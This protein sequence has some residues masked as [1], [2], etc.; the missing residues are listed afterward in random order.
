MPFQGQANQQYQAVDEN[1]RDDS[2]CASQGHGLKQELPGYVLALCADGFADADLASALGHADEHDV[3]YAHP[4]D[5]QTHGTEH[6][7]GQ[8]YHSDDAVE[9]LYF[10]LGGANHEIILGVVSHVSAAAK[11]FGGLID[12]LIEHVGVGLKT[13]IVFVGA[14]INFVEGAVR[15]QDA[16]IFIA[17]TETTFRLFDYAD[18]QKDRAI[19]QNVFAYRVAFRE[20]NGCD[21]LAQHDHLFAVKV[22]SFTDEPAGE[23]GGVGIDLA[24][25]RLDAAKIDGGDFAGLGAH[26][27]VLLP[28]D[29]KHGDVF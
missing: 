23:G 29:Q 26:G 27:V 15:D 1:E 17:H 4:A 19:D 16:A 9:F 13:N 18:H 6:Y 11:K 12:G 3:H 21:V 8:G 10:L 28:P 2:P 5:Q 20:E 25:I 14:G 7:R 24:K 22:I